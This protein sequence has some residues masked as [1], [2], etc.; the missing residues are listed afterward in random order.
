MF[1][2]NNIERFRSWFDQ[3]QE[4]KRLFNRGG[5][6]YP[7]TSRSRTLP[8]SNPKIIPEN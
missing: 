5:R 2:P 7:D 3:Q 8:I 4:K 6:Y 1:G